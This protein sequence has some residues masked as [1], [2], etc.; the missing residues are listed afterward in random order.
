[1]KAIL[2]TALLLGSEHASYDSKHLLM[3]GDI[4]LEHPL[5][6]VHSEKAWIEGMEFEEGSPMQIYLEEKVDFLFSTGAHLKC[7][8]AHFDYS[9][10][11]AFFLGKKISYEDKL[12][13]KDLV[14]NCL[15]LEAELIPQ[16]KALSLFDIQTMIF[17]GEVEISFD[18]L[19]AEGGKA[20]FKRHSLDTEKK[21]IG[22]LDLYPRLLEMNCRLS[23]SQAEIYSKNVRF[24][25]QKNSLF[26]DDPK[27]K[28]LFQD[29]M[30]FSAKQLT[31]KKSD[32]LWV[33]EEK[34]SLNSSSFFL[35]SDHASL[36]YSLKDEEP[37]TILFEGNVH[38]ISKANL[39][40][41][42]VGIAD[43]IRYFP[44]EKKLILKSFSP[45]KVLLLQEENSLQL[46]APEIHII[47]D[48]ARGIGDVRCTFQSD[49]EKKLMEFF[50]SYLQFNL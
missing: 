18:Q 49:E 23:H 13:E 30:F 27:G 16:K 11:K 26:F 50:E 47:N 20:V 15:E 1:M 25:L 21:W 29:P 12:E 43:E 33:F 28:L 42:S 8:K 41:K 14:I 32:D 3:K 31:W 39:P 44:S 48:Q 38:F 46:S 4:T 24:D 17:Q 2:L 6:K 7:D 40:K 9:A 35:S 34:V 19:K 37:K 10:K 45:K 36:I 22:F 5:G